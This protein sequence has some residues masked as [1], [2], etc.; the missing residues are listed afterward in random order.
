M[1]R[2]Q[3]EVRT[4]FCGRPGCE[5]PQSEAEKAAMKCPVCGKAVALMEIKTETSFFNYKA[6]EKLAEWK[7]W[8]LGKH[9]AHFECSNCGCQVILPGD[10][11][12]E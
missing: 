5:W 7:T 4:P 9:R 8:K 1:C 2:C 12:F 11:K 10:A 3:P 6:I